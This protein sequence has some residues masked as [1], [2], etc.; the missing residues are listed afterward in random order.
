MSDFIQPYTPT[1]TTAKDL[2]LQKKGGGSY[3][4]NL[5]QVDAYKRNQ[6]LTLY[7]QELFGAASTAFATTQGSIMSNPY[8]K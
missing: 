8:Q 7:A 5:A 3:T 4:G 1:Q 6:L 2:I